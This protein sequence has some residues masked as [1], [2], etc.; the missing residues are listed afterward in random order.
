MKIRR[1]GKKPLECTDPNTGRHVD[2]EA[3]SNADLSYLDNDNFWKTDRT[4]QTLED[5]NKQ[6][7]IK[8]HMKHSSAGKAPSNAGARLM[9]KTDDFKSL[10]SAFKTGG[11]IKNASRTVRSRFIID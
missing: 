8:S 7:S 1:F 4:S 9:N 11:S 3:T 5:I 2:G 6:E 10:K